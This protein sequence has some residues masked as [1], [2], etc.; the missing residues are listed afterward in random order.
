MLTKKKKSH[1]GV[2]QPIYP[3][4][5]LGA[6]TW[7]QV[8]LTTSLAMRF[9]LYQH[10]QLGLNISMEDV[11]TWFPTVYGMASVQFILYVEVSEG[12]PH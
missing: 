12:F 1:S 11:F 8:D 6:F 9:T 2:S 7:R 5:A 3:Q 10:V 4:D